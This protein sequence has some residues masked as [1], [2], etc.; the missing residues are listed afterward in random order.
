MG[1]TAELVHVRGMCEEEVRGSRRIT[2]CPCSDYT[3]CHRCDSKKNFLN[4]SAGGLQKKVALILESDFVCVHPVS[5]LTCELQNSGASAVLYGTS[6][7]E[8]HTLQ[9]GGVKPDCNPVTAA[10]N[11]LRI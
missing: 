2:V 5:M 6:D 8:T 11:P 10:P 9:S 4:V 3:L 7:L 1:L